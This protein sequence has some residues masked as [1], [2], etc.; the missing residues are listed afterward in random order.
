M[1]TATP[2]AVSGEIS[3]DSTAVYTP[4]EH[5]A[6]TTTPLAV[7]TLPEPVAAGAAWLAATLSPNSNRTTVRASQPVGE[8]VSSYS[9]A[10]ALSD[11]GVTV[12]TSGA[13]AGAKRRYF[14]AT[15]YNRYCASAL[16]G[17]GGPYVAP[18]AH[19]ATSNAGSK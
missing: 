6:V 15:A 17:H 2:T 9:A 8:F 5:A 16:V 3:G 10:A 11:E 4:P 18:P 1:R 13:A 19:V 12:S 14:L 7:A